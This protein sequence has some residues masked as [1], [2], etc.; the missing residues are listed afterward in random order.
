MAGIIKWVEPS[1]G[2]ADADV[3]IV[4][5]AI[6]GTL[7]TVPVG[8]VVG[9]LGTASV[10]VAGVGNA[11]AGNYASVLGGSGHNASGEYAVIGGGNGNVASSP[12]TT[13]AGGKSCTAGANHATNGQYAAVGGGNLCVASGTGATVVGGNQNTASGNYAVA[14]GSYALAY[15]V[16]MVAQSSGTFSGA[17]NAQRSEIVVRRATAD[18][19]PSTLSTNGSAAGATNSLVLQN[20]SAVVWRAMVVVKQAGGQNMAAWHIQGMASKGASAGSVLVTTGV[21]DVLGNVGLVGVGVSVGADVVNGALIITATG[22][23]G[24]SLRWVCTLSLT[25]VVYA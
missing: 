23:S 19:V 2:I 8:T 22:L 7:H 10:V 15:G 6:S 20:N 17:G 25:E 5:K 18:G 24:V 16:G 4:T 12:N 11:A 3:V 13:V 1:I 14:M 21:S 9:V